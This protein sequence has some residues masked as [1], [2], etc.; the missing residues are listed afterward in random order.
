[1][2]QGRLL[3]VEENL[4]DATCLKEALLQTYPQTRI[5][6][7][8]DCQSAQEFL[9]CQ[10][11]PNLILVAISQSKPEGKTFISWARSYLPNVSVLALCGRNVFKTVQEAQDS[12]V[13][14]L[15]L[16]PSSPTQWVDLAYQIQD[17]LRDM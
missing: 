4:T 13:A 7:F 5:L 12:G 1:M 9:E 2:E 14:L 10:S 17:F 16:K 11:P 8:E 3:F 6:H 15:L